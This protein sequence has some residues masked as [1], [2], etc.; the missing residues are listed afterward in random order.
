MN[1]ARSPA[2]SRLE[3]IVEDVFGDIQDE[4]EKT[5]DAPPRIDVRAEDDGRGGL[6]DIDA[7]AYIGDANQALE[8]LGVV[9]P[10]SDDY[11]TV[12]G[13]VLSTLGHM[14]EVNETFTH[15]ADGLLHPGGL[16][17]ACPQSPR[18]GE[19]R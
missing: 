10:T 8:Q 15:G 2:W 7:R 6:A 11:D 5:E 9:I 1:T 18:A 14:P 17:D 4:F 12:G 19:V 13:F 16:P 3:D